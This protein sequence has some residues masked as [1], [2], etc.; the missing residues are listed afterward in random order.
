MSIYVNRGAA[1]LYTPHMAGTRSLSL[2][3]ITFDAAVAASCATRI[4]VGSD[5]RDATYEHE[6]LV[7]LRFVSNRGLVKNGTAGE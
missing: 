3:F 7:E 2:L 1:R 4:P 5:F 6:T